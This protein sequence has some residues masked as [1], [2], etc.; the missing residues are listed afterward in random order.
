MGTKFEIPY[1]GTESILEVYAEFANHIGQVYGR[2]EDSY[3]QGRNTTKSQ[4][5]T[6]SDIKRVVGILEG[7]NIPFSYVL[8]GNNHANREYNKGYRD[9]FVD[10][11]KYLRDIG[12]KSIILSN[13]FLIEL[14]RNSVPDVEV[15]VSILLEIDNLARIKHLATLGVSRIVLSKTL[16][17][18]FQ[19]LE[20]IAKQ[21]PSNL[22][23]VLLV[24]DPCLHHCAYTQYHNQA[25]SLFSSKGGEYVNFCRLRCTQDFASDVRKVISAS[26]VRP[27]DLCHYEDLGYY[28]YK[29]TDRKQTTD[30]IKRALEAYTCRSYKGN[31]SDIM[32]PWSCYSG[33]YP[34]V[35]EIC[36]IFD[37]KDLLC[38]RSNLRFSPYIENELMSGYLDFWRERRRAGCANEDCDNCNYCLK[39][40]TSACR[41]NKDKMKIII[42]NTQRALDYAIRLSG[43][44]KEDKQ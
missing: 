11:V 16:L 24:N 36:E 17:K 2:A 44:K 19:A 40:A 8:N 13:I 1:N 41:I 23:L 25:L 27:E 32:S 14:I 9:N 4:I 28:L 5:I 22:D 34:D 42:H 12:V 35:Q 31:L 33:E 3:P 39:I 26:F 37:E 30:W 20:A 21:C 15:D 18:N 6:L 29:L 10:F 43:N 38:N 7:V